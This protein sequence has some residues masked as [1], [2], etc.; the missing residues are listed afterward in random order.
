[1][2]AAED[3]NPLVG[4]SLSACGYQFFGKRPGGPDPASVS[5]TQKENPGPRPGH[6]EDHALGVLRRTRLA[7]QLDRIQTPLR[8]PE[9][10]FI[11]IG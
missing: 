1:V 7:K 6:S 11:W 9:F 5:T 4:S 2:L 3:Q 8:D 10:V